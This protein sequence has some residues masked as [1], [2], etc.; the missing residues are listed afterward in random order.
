M[1]ACNAWKGQSHLSTSLML[2]LAS[3]QN[4]DG[5]TPSPQPE[6]TGI[7]AGSTRHH[8]RCP[9]PVQLGVDDPKHGTASWLPSFDSWQKCEGEEWEEYMLIFYGPFRRHANEVPGKKGILSAFHESQHNIYK[10]WDSNCI[11]QA[12]S[13]WGMPH[14]NKCCPAWRVVDQREMQKAALQSL[15]QWYL[16]EPCRKMPDK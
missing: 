3:H 10:N 9:R 5:D 12:Q 14:V 8:Q 6:Q 7:T 13:L 15:S 16:S 2:Y 1:C 11:S 4:I